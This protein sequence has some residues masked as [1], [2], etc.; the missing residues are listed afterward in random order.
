MSFS[1]KRQARQGF[2]SESVAVGSEYFIQDIKQKLAGRIRGR[3]IVTEN[4][5]TMLKEPL[6]SYSTLFNAQKAPLS[7]KNTYCLEIK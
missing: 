7:L 4:E 1:M 3:S 6:T 2:W 5:T